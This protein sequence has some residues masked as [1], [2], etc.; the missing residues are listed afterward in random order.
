M[1][2][3]LSGLGYQV[4]TPSELFGSREKALG[5]PDDQW[6]PM[7]GQRGWVVIASDIHIFQ[8]PHEHQA[9]LK[10]RV[11]VFLL[12]GE[13]KIEERTTLIA[14]NLSAMCSE[15]SQFR[16]GVWRLT[17]R[18][19][20]PYV[21]PEAKGKGVRRPKTVKCESSGGSLTWLTERFVPVGDGGDI[22]RDARSRSTR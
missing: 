16:S 4:H 9:Y 3:L 11:A 17:L 22:Q 6:L 5:A 18:G 19:A 13:S 12:P 8:R 1:R 14:H 15:A 7:V 21:A 10:A 20:E 2:K